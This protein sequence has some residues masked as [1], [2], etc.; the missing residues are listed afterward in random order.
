MF[1]LNTVDLF[2]FISSKGIVMVFNTLL[3]IMIC[4]LHEE[5]LPIMYCKHP[6]GYFH[7]SIH[8]NKIE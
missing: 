1:F 6:E 7:F 8:K 5:R 2:S 4:E 3:S